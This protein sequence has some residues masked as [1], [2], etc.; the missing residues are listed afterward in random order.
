MIFATTLFAFAIINTLSG[1]PF[2]QA[3]ENDGNGGGPA[4]F[5]PDA[6][7]YG[8]TYGEWTA[9]WWQWAYSMPEA[10]NPMVDN[11]GNN[12]AHNQSGPVWFVAGTGGGAV[13]REC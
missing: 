4:V 11:T 2:V 3:Q 9:K 8:L 7:P 10:D 1:I 5:P 13:T 6:K 12:C